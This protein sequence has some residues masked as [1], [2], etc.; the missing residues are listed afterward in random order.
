MIDFNSEFIEQKKEEKK[1]TRKRKQN[2]K[3]GR[4]KAAERSRRRSRRSRGSKQTREG[5]MNVLKTVQDYLRKMLDAVEGMKV[6]LMDEE[7]VRP[8]SLFSLSPFPS[9]SLLA[10]EWMA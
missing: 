10:D 8:F 1:K 9:L 6:L 3:D 2:K 4:K 5:K 7:T